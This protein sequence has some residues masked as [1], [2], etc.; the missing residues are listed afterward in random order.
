[1]NNVEIKKELLFWIG[2]IDSL[3]MN[4]N[5]ELKSKIITDIKNWQ[6][7]MTKIDETEITF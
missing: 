6:K 5:T 3:H 4:L 1:M 2:E 7:I